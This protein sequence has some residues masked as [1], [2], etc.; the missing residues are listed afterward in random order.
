MQYS[1]KVL[2]YNIHKGFS[3]GNREYVLARIREAIR[4]TEADIVGLQEVLGEHRKHSNRWHDWHHEAHF[5]YLADQAWP[6]F[7]YGKNA[8][9]EH[10]HHGNA[11]LSRFEFGPTKNQDLSYSPFSRRG[12]LHGEVVIQGHRIQLACL[13]LGF[14]PFEQYRQ[15]RQLSRWLNDLPQS[16][17]LLLMGDFND[18]HLRIHNTLTRHNQLREATCYLSQRNRPQATYPVRNPVAAMD[19]VYYRGLEL[20]QCSVGTQQQWSKLSDHCPVLAE[21]TLPTAN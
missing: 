19:R 18:W 5:E 4:A 20:L 16:Q 15:L 3:P 17:P 8:I 13:H 12:L 1:I 7:A 10:G 9:Y 11:I 21:F 2:S 14:M 6:H